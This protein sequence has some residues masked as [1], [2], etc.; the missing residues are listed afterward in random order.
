MRQNDRVGLRVRQPKPAEHMRKLMLER[1]ARGEHDAGKPGGDETFCAC[2]TVAAVGDHARQ[3]RS[4]SLQR[5]ARQSHQQWGAVCDP[6]GLDAMRDGVHSARGAH[7]CRQCQC[8]LGVIDD[9]AWQHAGVLTGKFLLA[10]A[11]PPNRGRFRPGI[12]GRHRDDRQAEIPRDYFREPDRGAAAGGDEA[13]GTARGRD[14]HLSH[15][16][17]DV[18]S[19]LRM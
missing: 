9:R 14:A 4:K 12:G 3:V 19:R 2:R 13:V 8:E 7:R 11:E 17:R 16:L 10:V 6:K 15:W 5:V 18:Q 1:G